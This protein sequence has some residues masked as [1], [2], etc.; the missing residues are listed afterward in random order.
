[1]SQEKNS[2]GKAHLVRCGWIFTG[3]LAVLLCIPAYV[4]ASLW[5]TETKGPFKNRTQVADLEQDGDLD[6]LVSHTRWEGVDLSWA[7]IGM[8][9][10][11]G[12]GDFELVRVS[13]SNNFSGFAAGAGDV[14]RDGDADVYVWE[15]G[16]RLLENQGGV[17]SGEPG[18]FL[19]STGINLPPA[20]N[21]GYRDMGGTI[22]MGD[23][24]ADG[25]VDA[26]IAGCCYGL[27]P[28]PPGYDLP[29]APSVSWV[30]INDGGTQVGRIGHILPMD[31]LDGLPIRQAALGDLDGDGD[32]D[33]FAAVDEPTMGT[34]VS[35]GDL[36]LLNDGTGH[37][38]AID[39]RF[40]DTD[41]TSVSLGDVN[42]DRR[43]DALVGAGSEARLWINQGRSAGRG[44]PIFT[45]AE[46][47][48][49][50]SQGIS[51]RQQA[52]FSLTIARLTGLYLPYGSTRTA[53][54]FL[55][56]LDEDEDL[57]AL[58]AR[59]WEAELWWNDGRGQFDRSDVRMEYREDTGV[60][61]G[62]FDGDGDQDIFT[63]NNGEV[64]R[65]WWNDGNRVFRSF[66]EHQGLIGTK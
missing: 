28:T 34:I 44:A 8:W 7:G 29:H 10:N 26:F 64:Y 55:A 49:E 43:L 19:P 52:G 60:A 56:D 14:D 62:D 9:I 46:G 17:Q 16:I 25:W 1:M 27:A 65:L 36:I 24:N 57:D 48:F 32:M 5:Y 66:D 59:I 47:S 18:R 31:S 63:G 11:Q 13:R 20:Y 61:V 38:S 4:G 23:L 6:V 35:S 15:S 41:S 22:V 39:P 50:V 45:S 40:G 58:I 53:A 30:W 51:G 3:I 2:F 12:N 54:V 21:L 37:L 33:F 42:G